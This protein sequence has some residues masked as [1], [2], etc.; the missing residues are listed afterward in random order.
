MLGMKRWR[1]SASVLASALFVAT[2][3]AQAQ[4]NVV[5]MQDPGG[6]YGDALRKVM[7]DPFEKETG[8][9]V[10]TV[11]EAR[12]GPRIKA[13]AEAG[14]A[15]WDLT[16]IFDQ[17]T[18]LLGDCCLADIDYSKLSE[19]AKQTL[20]AMPDNL[21][22]KKGVALQVIGVGLVY[23]KDKYKGENVPTSWADFWDVKKFPG[24]RC[25][26]AWPR[27]VFE[28]A[29]MADGVEKSKLY[30]IDVERALKKV[31]EIKPHI[32][33]WWTT[34]AQPPQ[35]L[36]DGEAD[37]CMAYTGSMSKLALEGAPIELTF[38]QGFVYY[39]FFSIPKGAP[40]HDNALK[41]L[42]WRLEPKRA[43]QLTSTFPVALPSSVVFAAA[44]DKKLARYWANNPDNVSKAIEWSPDYWGAASPAGNSTNEEYG[45]EKLNALLAQ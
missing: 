18:K 29:L 30:P 36:L 20:A 37:M 25:M 42:S 22:R 10:V 19:A 9:K 15:Q 3:L 2:G 38:N 8:I 14:K 11:Q 32:A 27:F 16:F 39:D 31:K 13:Q 45:Q 43:A 24:R 26:P 28:A 1:L 17:E 7:Y 21:K 35:L 12:S 33:K 6:G 44:T 40:N 23:N 41:L 34:A 4:N 5:I